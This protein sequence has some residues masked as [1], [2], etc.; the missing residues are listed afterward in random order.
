MIAHVIMMEKL[1]FNYYITNGDNITM[2]WMSN[3]E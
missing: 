3:E 2:Y 1:T